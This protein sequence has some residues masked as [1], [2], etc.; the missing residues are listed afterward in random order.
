M[1][2]LNIQGTQLQG[3]AAVDHAVVYERCAL[4]VRSF[5]VSFLAR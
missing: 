2:L 1:Q 3:G 4:A 5:L